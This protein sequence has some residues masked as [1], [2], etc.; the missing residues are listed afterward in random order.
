[1]C[2]NVFYRCQ[3]IAFNGI[4]WHSAVEASPPYCRS[5]DVVFVYCMFFF[6]FTTGSVLLL[7]IFTFLLLYFRS[8]LHL[9]GL[10]LEGLGLHLEKEQGRPVCLLGAQN[11]AAASGAKTGDQFAALTCHLRTDDTLM[12]AMEDQ[13][14]SLASS[15]P[16]MFPRHCSP[17]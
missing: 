7:K 1:M 9:L 14:D 16:Q 12:D 10:L 3:F 15:C 6:L 8:Q 2:V 4:I 17:V 13:H 5:F 11:C